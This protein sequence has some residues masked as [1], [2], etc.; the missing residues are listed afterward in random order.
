MAQALQL[1]AAEDEKEREVD[2]EKVRERLEEK[3]NITQQLRRLMSH[4]G[5]LTIILVQGSG[6]D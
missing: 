6:R 3:E 5:S 4:E 1:R 2:R